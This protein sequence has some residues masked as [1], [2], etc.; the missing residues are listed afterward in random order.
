[1]KRT[2]LAVLAC[3][4]LVCPFT[5]A[6]QESSSIAKGSSV[7]PKEE[8]ATKEDVVALLDVMHSR[9]TVEAMFK[10]M[11]EQMLTGMHDSILKDHPNASPAVLKKL[12]G[13]MDGVFKYLNVDDVTAISIP[14]YQ[15][16]LS[17]D[18]AIALIS[19]Y[20]SPTGQRFLDRM[21]ALV[22][23]AGEAGANMMRSHM[24]EVQDQAQKK[25]E[26]FQKYIAAHP[27]ELG[28]RANKPVETP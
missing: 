12:D 3:A 16:Y 5:V 13:T 25:F 14:I 18:D 4:V 23:E 2:W 7:V 22:K 21:P 6:Q 19:F 8:Q 24:Q 20:S 17:H 26:D 27:E 11:R 28:E 15:K 9:R 10:M 1:M